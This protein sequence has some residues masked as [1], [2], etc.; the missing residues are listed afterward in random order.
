MRVDEPKVGRVRYIICH[1]LQQLDTQSTLAFEGVSMRLLCFLTFSVATTSV[2]ESFAQILKT[3]N[4]PNM[5]KWIHYFDAYER[6][7]HQFRNT[8]AV[9]LE[10]G[11][12]NGGSLALW[13]RY[14]GN[15]ARIFGADFYDK[16]V[17]MENNHLY[18]NPN[19]IIIG[20][21]GDKKFWYDVRKVVPNGRLDVIIDDGSHNPAH[22]ALS[23]RY[24]MQLLQPGGVYIC[25]DVHASNNRFMN[26]IWKFLYNE[27]A[28]KLTLN[29]FSFHSRTAAAAQKRVF[30]ITFYPYL[31]IL[32]KM[33]TPRNHLLGKE[34]GDLRLNGSR[35]NWH[36]KSRLT[37]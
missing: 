25:E 12:K 29:T 35:H 16:S 8:S 36:V 32:E 31:V 3:W 11:L 1:V 33:R 7:L 28:T 10:I 17:V 4:G 2:R 15:Y 30:A 18:G 9:L 14:L 13:R 22:M 34:W 37:L 23:L 21:Q 5:G 27:D 19:G 20:D 6:H 26:H 24:A